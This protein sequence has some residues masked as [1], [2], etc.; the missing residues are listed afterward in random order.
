MGPAVT[1]L[2]SMSR[3]IDLFMAGSS[4]L[5]WAEV[6]QSTKE[7]AALLR[8]ATDPS[9]RRVA[10][11]VLGT[12]RLSPDESLR[13]ELVESPRGSG[14]IFDTPVQ[15]DGSFE[16]PQVQPRVYEAIVLKTC[17]SCG[18]SKGLGSPVRV[19][20]ANKDVSGLRLVVPSR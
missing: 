5:S 15:S 13:V 6:L 10:G 1:T 8:N 3:L 9:L 11:R 20:I 17:K 16:F 4:P 12:A 18:V 19:V 14:L 2:M 7:P